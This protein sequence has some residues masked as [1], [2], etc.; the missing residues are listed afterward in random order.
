MIFISK[1]EN[2]A[3]FEIEKILKYENCKCVEIGLPIP[4]D[5][6]SEELEDYDN[7]NYKILYETLYFKLNKNQKY[8]FDDIIQNLDN[9]SKLFYIDGPGGTGKTFLYTVLIYYFLSKD[10][11][12]L[13]MAWTGIAAILLPK[14]MT[15]H[16]TFGLPLD[17]S[18]A[19]VSYLKL[20]DKDKLLSCK[21]FRNEIK[22]SG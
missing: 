6:S 19:V 1:S 9:D 17:L 12:I 14:G 3:L 7:K 2:Y 13:T 18:S 8:I 11:K 16:R 21:V 15:T 10:I 5:I 22:Y 4:H 20:L